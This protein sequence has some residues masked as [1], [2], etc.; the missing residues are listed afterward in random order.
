MRDQQQTIR[1]GWPGVLLVG[2]LAVVVVAGG[3][4]LVSCWSVAAGVIVLAVVVVAGGVVVC[5]QGCW[6]GWLVALL[7]WFVTLAKN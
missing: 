5:W 3:C 7:T 2:V 6:L 1:V 4:L